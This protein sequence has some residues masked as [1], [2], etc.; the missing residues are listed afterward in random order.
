MTCSTAPPASSSYNNNNNNNNNNN[1]NNNNNL[2]IWRL[3]LESPQAVQT[4]KKIENFGKKIKYNL[5]KISESW[6][7]SLTY[8]HK[9]VCFSF[10]Q[11]ISSESF[12]Y[13]FIYFFKKE[14]KLISVFTALHFQWPL[15]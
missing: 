5:N 13:L 14:Q 6:D 10:H 12:I 9:K 3:F 7:Q 15:F 11:D 2:F 8:L 1:D 4:N